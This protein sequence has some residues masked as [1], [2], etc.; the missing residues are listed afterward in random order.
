MLTFDWRIDEQ[1]WV[2]LKQGSKPLSQVIENRIQHAIQT[3]AFNPAPVG[4]ISILLCDDYQMQQLNQQ[5]RG[6]DKATNVLSF[7]APEMP[8]EANAGIVELGDIALGYETVED[9]AFDRKVS[10]L[11]HSTH[12]VI[13]GILHLL[14]F[15]HEIDSDAHVMEELERKIMTAISLHDPYPDQV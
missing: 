14:G 2:G 12:L 8:V 3:G 9:E 4:N 1:E 11:D 6:Q 7:P 13:H 10:I 15:D 5:F